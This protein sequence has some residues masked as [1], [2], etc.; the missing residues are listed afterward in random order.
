MASPN[1]MLGWLV[2]LTLLGTGFVGCHLALGIEEAETLAGGS[3]GTGGTTS[4]CTD[5]AQ[6]DDDNFCTV[7]SCIDGSCD[8]PPV[9][10]GDAPAD[11]QTA[12]DCLRV[13]CIAGVEQDTA[14]ETDVPTDGQECTADLCT[15]GTPSNPV[16]P[17]ETAC[18]QDGGAL[19]NDEGKCVECYSNA[20]C[21]TPATCGGGGTPGSCGCTPISCGPTGANLT[22][23]FAADDGCGSALNCDNNIQ[24]GTE[25]DV[26]CGGSVATC[27]VRCQDGDS[28]VVPSDCASTNCDQLT[29]AP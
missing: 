23:G 26:D 17:A 27:S 5:A 18:S 13:Q 6:C 20:Q 3:G 1:R 25:T 14:D 12:G 10:D 29:C 7:D 9:D 21:T 19:C 16:L 24:D 2:P 11:Q 28:C 4:G 22:C 8:N 15:G